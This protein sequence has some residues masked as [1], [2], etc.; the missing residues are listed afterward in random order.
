MCYC[1]VFGC[2]GFYVFSN[3]LLEKNKD[4]LLQTYCVLS[5]CFIFLLI[6]SQHYPNCIICG[7]EK[8][9]FT[10]SHD[11]MCQ[12]LTALEYIFQAEWQLIFLHHFD[13]H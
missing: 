1:K 12:Y 6:L 9:A 2:F 8:C 7:P 4:L 3:Q 5:N 10:L 11:R 13:E